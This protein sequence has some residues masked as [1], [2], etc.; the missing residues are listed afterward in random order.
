MALSETDYRKWAN[1]TPSQIGVELCKALDRIDALEK[2]VL[3]KPASKAAPKPASKAKSPPPEPT[4]PEPPK[5]V[6]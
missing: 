2:I 6:K 1:L 3:P 4:P 5:S